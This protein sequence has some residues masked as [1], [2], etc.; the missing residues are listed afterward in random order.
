MTPRY[1]AII[2]YWKDD[3][4]TL[5]REH[6]VWDPTPWV[7]DIRSQFPGSSKAS[8]RPGD[9]DRYTHMG[10]L[11][12]N[13]GADSWPIHGKPGDWYFAGATVDGET[14]LGFRTEDMMRRF[15]AAFPQ[16]VIERPV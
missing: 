16:S 15:C 3:P 9:I 8:N 6:Q 12:E 2:A 10:W 1:H 11:R 14:W 4:E 7:I 13:I 5:Q